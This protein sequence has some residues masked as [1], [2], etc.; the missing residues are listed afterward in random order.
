MCAGLSKLRMRSKKDRF[1]SYL[2][3]KRQ[4]IKILL[5]KYNKKVSNMT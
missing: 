3:E 4:R 2:M 5:K 1:E